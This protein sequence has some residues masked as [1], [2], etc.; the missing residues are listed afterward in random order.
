MSTRKMSLARI[1]MY[2]NRGSTRADRLRGPCSE[3]G[4]ARCLLN[5]SCQVGTKFVII[6]AALTPADGRRLPSVQE[7]LYPFEPESARPHCVEDL[8]KHNKGESQYSTMSMVLIKCNG[9]VFTLIQRLIIVCHHRTSLCH[10]V[11]AN[12]SKGYDYELKNNPTM[13]RS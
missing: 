5:G 4:L 6:P 12:V 10:M 7:R 3:T 9:N 1:I 13:N 11:V 8:I 2:D